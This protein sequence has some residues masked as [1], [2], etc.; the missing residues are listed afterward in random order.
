MSVVDPRLIL[1]LTPFISTILIELATSGGE[2]KFNSEFKKIPEYQTLK[3]K[4]ASV[5]NIQ[6]T[7]L[8]SFHYEQSMRYFDF[9]TIAAFII[10]LTR[11]YTVQTE[12]SLVVVS[13]AISICVIIFLRVWTRRYFES[14]TPNEYAR[15]EPSVELGHIEVRKGDGAVIIANLIPVISL[16]VLEYL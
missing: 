14:K 4:G 3:S 6:N 2:G 12:N 15:K 1:E 16:V 13:G 8:L 7:A 5:N 10:F 11:L 9:A